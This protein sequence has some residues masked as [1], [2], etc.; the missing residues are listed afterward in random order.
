MGL[1]AQR[2]IHAGQTRGSAAAQRRPGWL[3]VSFRTG[4]EFREVRRIVS[5]N[6]LHT[7]C[8]SARCP[9]VG[10]CWGA[11]T[12]TFMILGAVCTRSC[13]FCAVQTGRPAKPDTSEPGRVAA[14]V[15]KLGL[16]HAVITSV[17]RDD[18]RDGG[19]ELW[20]ETIRAVRRRS[21]DCRIE[22]LIPDFRGCRTSLRRVIDAAPDI[23]NHNIETVPRLYP[24]VR[25]QADYH[26]SLGVIGYA[27]EAGM[28]TKSGIIVGIGES[29]DEVAAV[30]DDLRKSGCDIMTI[31]QYLQPTRA[32]LPVSRYVTP[33]EFAD[34]RTAG[35]RLGFKYVESGPLVR[36]SYHAREQVVKPEER[37]A[38]DNA[39]KRTGH[40]GVRTL[41]QNMYI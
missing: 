22:A 34:F 32:H 30:M 2:R 4:D 26:Q 23:L 24:S 20:A 12:A 9:N 6:R 21:P 19:S 13:G 36:S 31:G 37:T 35:L 10:E 7:V 5:D 41:R 33:G 3:K 17:D 38:P 28:V 39:G 18:L 1:T 25:P 40:A 27:K 15:E 16:K 11:R 8:E 14:A 29:N